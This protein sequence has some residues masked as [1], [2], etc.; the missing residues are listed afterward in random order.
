MNL[1]AWLLYF[2]NNEAESRHERGF[3]VAFLLINTVAL[4]FGVV[5]FVIE[6]EPQWIP[7][8]IIEYIWALDSIRHNRM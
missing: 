7:V 3:D 1:K 6:Q 5:M 4:L 8:L 2:T